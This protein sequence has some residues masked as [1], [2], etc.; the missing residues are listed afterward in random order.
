MLLKLRSD[1]TR[2]FTLIELLVVIAIIGILATLLMPALMKAKEKANKTKC[3]NSL[4]QIGLAALQYSDDK[5]FLP[6]VAKTMT[7][8]GDVSSADTPIAMQVMVWGGYFDNPEAFIC[9]S[10]VDLFVSLDIQA[11]DNIRKWNW[12]DQGGVWATPTQSPILTA[13]PT[14]LDQLT[15]LSYGWTRRG[16]NTNVRSNTK[17]GADRA[18]IAEAESQSGTGT[19]DALVG[20]HSDGWEVL[21]ADASVI[22]MA[23]AAD[24]Y[25][26]SILVGTASRRDGFL[27]IRDQ[28][29]VEIMDGG[30]P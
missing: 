14:A 30:G 27:P 20:N 23:V 15:E 24:P 26:G 28:T 25:P 10:S 8:D 19:G 2:G 21:Q 7:L 11:E 22:W 17:L 18:V 4:R 9:P 13:S 6:H 29:Q 12:G 3:S 16:L 5:R 1:R